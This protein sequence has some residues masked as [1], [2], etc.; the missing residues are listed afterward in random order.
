MGQS[1]KGSPKENS[2]NSASNSDDRQHYGDREAAQKNQSGQIKYMP[3]VVLGIILVMS[4]AMGMIWAMVKPKRL[5]FAIEFGFIT[6]G[7]ISEPDHEL[8][9]GNLSFVMRSYIPNKKSTIH[10]KSMQIGNSYSE[11]KTTTPVKDVKDFS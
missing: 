10:Y 5:V 2:R 1:E 11:N 9:S 4:A 8:F 6:V 3:F 7:T